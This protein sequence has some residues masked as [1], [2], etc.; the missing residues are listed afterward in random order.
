LRE[1]QESQTGRAKLRER[2]GVEHRLAHL[3]N[4]QG[5]P[6]VGPTGPR[7][8]ARYVIVLERRA[9]G[10]VEHAWIPLKEFER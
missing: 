1:L 3:S 9:D 4:R 8:L 6:A 5:P 7:D 2:V 10:R